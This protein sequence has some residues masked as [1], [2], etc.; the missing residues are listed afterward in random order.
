MPT[1][2]FLPGQSRFF[3]SEAP[4]LLWSAALGVGKTTAGTLKL[5]HYAMKFPGSSCLVLR[6]TLDSVK[7]TVIRPHLLKILPSSFRSGFRSSEKNLTL[8]NKSVIH[9]EG[10]ENAYRL[11]SRDFGFI[12]VE[13]AVEISEESFN[14]LTNRNRHQA[15]DYNQIALITNPGAP[16]HWIYQ[17]LILGGDPDVE[18]FS[19]HFNEAAPIL[20]RDYFDRVQ[21]YTGFWR[22]RFVNAQWVSAGDGLVYPMYSPHRHLVDIFEPGR[23][24][25]FFGAVDFG[26]SSTH[27]L[28]FVWAA[29][30]IVTGEVTV[31]RH[32]YRTNIILR[33]A[34][35]IFRQ[36]SDTASLECVFC[37]HDAENIAQMR[38]EG[39]PVRLASKDVLQGVQCLSNF[40]NTDKL[41]I[42]RGS[43]CHRVDTALE[44]A[45][46]PTSG[47]Q[48]FSSYIWRDETPKKDRDDFLDTLRYLCYSLEK[49]G[50]LRLWLDGSGSSRGRKKQKIDGGF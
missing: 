33:D 3:L 22:E 1:F 44:L 46:R 12:L 42:V 15:G 37:D 27:P 2:N 19:T 50:F 34:M 28:V 35:K 4:I 26:F 7:S 45:G 48:E 10:L 40:L 18:H 5:L 49:Q 6:Q 14:F 16:S 23:N 43:L 36:F 20:R 13:E 21:R 25:R 24:H 11:Q 29:V 38:K 32:F 31:Y 30:D 17:R 9:W 47:E 39:F 8:P 41:K